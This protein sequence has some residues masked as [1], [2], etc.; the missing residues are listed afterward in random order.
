MRGVSDAK[1]C[2]AVAFLFNFPI[3]MEEEDVA[4]AFEVTTKSHDKLFFSFSSLSNLN[5]DKNK[6]DSPRLKPQI[7]K[8]VN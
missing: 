8:I 6:K 5:E 2:A 4:A 1:E 7:S 3:R